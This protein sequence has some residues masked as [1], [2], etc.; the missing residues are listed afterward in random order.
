MLR[1][2]AGARRAESGVR[3]SARLWAYLTDGSGGV[4]DSRGRLRL[5]DWELAADVQ[6]ELRERWQATTEDLVGGLADL[7]WFRQQIWQL[8][9]FDVPG[10]DYSQPIETEVPWPPVPQR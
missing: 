7:D 9:G 3:Q 5:D 1:S 8:Y 10:V 4:T 2:V 6:A